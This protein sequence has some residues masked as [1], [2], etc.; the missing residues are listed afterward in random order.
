MA[1]SASRNPPW[2]PRA[3]ARGGI[4]RNLHLFKLGDMTKLLDDQ[5]IW[6]SLKIEAL[7]SREIVSGILWGSVVAK[8]NLT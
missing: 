1:D 5:I 8:R 2:A 4:K 3:M 6:N 7:A